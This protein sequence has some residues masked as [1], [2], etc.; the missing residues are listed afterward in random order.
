MKKK[1]GDLTQTFITQSQG[2]ELLS[3]TNSK[4]PQSSLSNEEVVYDSLNQSTLIPIKREEGKLEQGGNLIILR[5]KEKF[6]EE[7]ILETHIEKRL[8]KVV[9]AIVEEEVQEKVKSGIES[10]TL[11]KEQEHHKKL[12]ELEKKLDENK[13]QAEKQE[14]ARERDLDIDGIYKKVYERIERSLVSERRR[15]GL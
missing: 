6:L 3:A 13:E 4:K 2:V 5:Q 9:R 11:A 14:K 8:Q 7:E 15:M 12:K 10:Y 1:T